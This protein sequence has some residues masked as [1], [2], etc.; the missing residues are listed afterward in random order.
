[1][2][3]PA[4]RPAG[5]DELAY[6]ADRF[7][8]VEVNS[9]FYRVPTPAT[10]RQWAR[11]TPPGFEFAVKLFQQFTHP[12]MFAERG[13]AAA[14]GPEDVDAFR[15]ALDPLA[16]ADKL[17]PVL[18][19]FP[20]SFVRDDAAVAYLEWLLDVF[21][22]VT[23]AVELRHR[24]WSDAEAETR[25]LLRSGGAAWVHIDEPKFRS[26]I[27]QD[28]VPEPGDLGYL[29]LH[30]RNAARWWDHDQAEDRYDYLYSG[31]ELE[32]FA[33]ALASAA[34]VARK[35]YLLLNNHFEAKAVAN[36]AMLKHRLGQPLP[37]AYPDSFLARFPALRGVVTASAPTPDS[38]F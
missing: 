1:M 19:Q 33:D 26:S 7:D 37:G 38:L 36:A 35:L 12:R 16:E 31:A 20:P 9:T 18:A 4:P 24:S 10:T 25:R 32:P 34:R 5:F 11:R 17:G 27:R 28:F 30:G 23:L 6:Y 8:T 21:R 13:G 15:R 14:I 22:D 29:R 3:Y 2:F